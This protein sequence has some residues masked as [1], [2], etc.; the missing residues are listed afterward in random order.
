MLVLVVC[1]G[2]GSVSSKA[3]LIG[4]VPKTLLERNFPTTTPPQFSWRVG[5]LRTLL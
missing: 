3:A 2:Q 1:V 4:L 5:V